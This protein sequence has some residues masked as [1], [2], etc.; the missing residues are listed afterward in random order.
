MG[1]DD[2]SNLEGEDV[3]FFGRSRSSL[4]IIAVV[5]YYISSFEIASLFESYLVETL[6]TNAFR[7]F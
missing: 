1:K 5:S 2:Y 6:E 4:A 3:I 7:P